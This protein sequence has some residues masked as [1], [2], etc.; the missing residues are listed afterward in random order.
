[1]ASYFLNGLGAIVDVLEPIRPFSPF[2]WY[3]G[4]TAP[5]ARGFGIGYLLLAIGALIGLGIS[6]WRF[7]KRD[8]AV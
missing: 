3:L 7:E 4:D 8:L 5:L 6:V 2:F 1:M